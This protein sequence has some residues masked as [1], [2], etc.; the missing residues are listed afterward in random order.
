MS[1]HIIEPVTRNAAQNR[2]E[3]RVNG[4]LA[5]VLEYDEADGRIDMTHTEVVEQYRHEGTAEALAGG[6][7]FDAVERDLTIVPTCPF[8]EAYLR[9][10]PISGARVD[11]PSEA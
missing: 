1:E 6:A 2:Y 7:I 4:D 9:K 10:Y 3:V 11:W 8:I 5:G